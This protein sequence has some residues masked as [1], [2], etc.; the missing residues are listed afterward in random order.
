MNNTPKLK[1]ASW[2]VLLL[3]LVAIC[4]GLLADGETAVASPDID[5]NWLTP[6][7]ITDIS[8]S[9][10]GANQPVVSGS[11]D[12]KTVMVVYN[13][14]M[15]ATDGDNDPYYRRSLNNGLTWLAP[16]A[17]RT[18]PAKESRQV[19]LDYTAN[20]IAH[21]TWQEDKGLVYT[22]EGSKNAGSW[23]GAYK[24]LVAPISSPSPGVSS[25]YIV[26]S[27]SN[28]IDIV[29]A[30][31]NSSFPDPNI[32]H[33]RSKD[34]GVTF[35]VAKKVV[36]NSGWASQFPS[37]AVEDQTGIVHLVWQE[38]H[39]FATPEKGSIVYSRGTESGGTMSWTTPVKISV[40]DD[41]REPDITL[42]NN[43]L[44]VVYTDFR[45]ENEQYIRHT[46]CSS[47]CT[48]IGGWQAT[49][50]AISG[51]ISGANGADP[52]NLVSDVARWGNCTVA[53]FHGTVIG[54]N[55]N[56]IIWGVDSCSGWSQSPR[57]QVTT[58]NMRSINPNLDVQNNWWFYLVYERGTGTA[59][60]QVYLQRTKPN[61]LLPVVFK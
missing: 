46:Q 41:A 35:S 44:Q 24:V 55:D 8:N 38:P 33:I 17:I 11:P 28:R 7:A 27:G 15:S 58:N 22:N 9:P 18:T 25:P 10:D 39:I 59:A 5:P 12:G 13:R 51:Q 56:E 23:N 60:R 42:A 19:H 4:F 32:Y 53:Y 14:R 48:S 47:T 50:N 52:L 49:T 1:F 2:I 61:V 29:W 40:V 37:M 45:G 30:E 20:G 36:L 43:T 57:D 16:A 6:V 31:G 26:A 54:P 3:T 34:G 21:V